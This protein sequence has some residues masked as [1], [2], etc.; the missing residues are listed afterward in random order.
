MA[1]TQLDKL[2]EEGRA[3][4]YDRVCEADLTRTTGRRPKLAAFLRYVE[5]FGP[6][7]VLESATHLATDQ[8]AILE[9]RVKLAIKN[10]KKRR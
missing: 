1:D 3:T 10:G 2:C 7:M 5:R 9:R 6:D 4:Q 8:Y